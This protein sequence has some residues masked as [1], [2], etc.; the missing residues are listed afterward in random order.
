MDIVAFHRGWTFETNHWTNKRWIKIYEWWHINSERMKQ[1]CIY[2]VQ[3]HVDDSTRCSTMVVP[4]PDTIPLYIFVLESATYSVMLID[5]VCVSEM[6]PCIILRRS[7]SCIFRQKSKN[8]R[9]SDSQN[10][11]WNGFEDNGS[12]CRSE[13][14][15]IWEKKCL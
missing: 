8:V 6:M 3:V 1:V 15:F 5:C 9:V 11:H 7:G 2:R 13:K 14:L 10:G 4:A 12:I